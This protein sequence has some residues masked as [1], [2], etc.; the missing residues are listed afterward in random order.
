M[1][2]EAL[3]RNPYSQLIQDNFIRSGLDLADYEKMAEIINRVTM[4]DPSFHDLLYLKALIAHSLGRSTEAKLALQQLMI[5]EPENQQ[6]K[7]LYSEIVGV[8]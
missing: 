5:S 6:A 1:F 4:A 7:E 3:M 2:C 8:A